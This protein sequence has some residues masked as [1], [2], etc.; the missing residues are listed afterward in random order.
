MLFGLRLKSVLYIR[1]KFIQALL[2]DNDEGT[3]FFS[4]II[5]E[6]IINSSLA[7]TDLLYIK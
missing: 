2:G 6:K 4:I 3:F 5:P 1:R 7:G